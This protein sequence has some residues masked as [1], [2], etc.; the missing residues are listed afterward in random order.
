MKKVF[1]LFVCRSYETSLDNWQVFHRNVHSIVGWLDQIEN[2]LM[3]CRKTDSN[4]DVEQA[5]LIQKVKKIL[6]F[7]LLLKIYLETSVIF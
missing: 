6:F 2:Q 1:V 7:R 4:L 3:E 5:E